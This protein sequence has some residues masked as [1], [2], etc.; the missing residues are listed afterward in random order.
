MKWAVENH[1][2]QYVHNKKL[3]C[4]IKKDNNNSY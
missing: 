2:S 1:G 3:K 4:E